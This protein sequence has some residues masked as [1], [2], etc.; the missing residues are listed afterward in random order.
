[1]PCHL[2]KARCWQISLYQN[3]ASAGWL[4]EPRVP[5]ETSGCHRHAH[6]QKILLFKKLVCAEIGSIWLLWSSHTHTHT[7]TVSLGQLVLE[8]LFI[9]IYMR[10]I[11]YAL[12]CSNPPQINH[13]LAKHHL[14]ETCRP[15]SFNVFFSKKNFPTSILFRGTP[16]LGNL[17]DHLL[18]PSAP[19]FRPIMVKTPAESESWK[20]SKGIVIKS[21]ST[22]SREIGCVCVCVHFCTFFGARNPGRM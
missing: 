21:F 6:G 17:Y 13:F 16:F 10:N 22:A 2:L 20:N 8:R 1:M 9:Y 15:H 18:T 14:H 4:R 5:W 7:H 12:N 19:W 11:Y 3:L